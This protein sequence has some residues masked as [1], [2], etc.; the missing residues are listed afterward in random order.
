MLCVENK[1]Q[2]GMPH[3]HIQNTE[4]FFDRVIINI[5]PTSQISTMQW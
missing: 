4:L 5:F 2:N 1:K 3:K